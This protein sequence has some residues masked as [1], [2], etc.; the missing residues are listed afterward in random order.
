MIIW[1]PK[2]SADYF[3]VY[4]RIVGGRRHVH[5][6]I[7]TLRTLQ[8][9][10]IA[11]M[12][13]LT[14]ERHIC[15]VIYLLMFITHTSTG[16]MGVG[17][18]II[19]LPPTSFYFITEFSVRKYVQTIWKWWLC[20]SITEDSVREYVQIL[21]KWFIRNFKTILMTI[22]HVYKLILTQFEKQNGCHPNFF[23]EPLQFSFVAFSKFQKY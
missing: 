12:A 15:P 13:T 18:G 19:N 7:F 14:T 8:V 21:W 22:K 20:N 4:F 23:L 11:V 17:S 9:F 1:T 3:A 16:S 6:L 2:G 5:R 10:T